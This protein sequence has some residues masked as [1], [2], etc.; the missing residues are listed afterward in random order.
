[1]RAIGASLAAPAASLVWAWQPGGRGSPGLDLAY[2]GDVMFLSRAGVGRGRQSTWENGTA[3]RS[4]WLWEPST[5]VCMRSSDN[6]SRTRDCQATVGVGARSRV[7]EPTE[8]RRR[9]RV[10]GPGSRGDAVHRPSASRSSVA[11]GAA[12]LCKASPWA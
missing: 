11:S 8:R 1:M 9:S 3:V 2:E 12:P 10:A 7:R 5:L 6:G 4:W